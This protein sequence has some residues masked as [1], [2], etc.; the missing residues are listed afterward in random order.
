MNYGLIVLDLLCMLILASLTHTHTCTHT[1]TH[2]HAHSHTHT[3]TPTYTHTFIKGPPQA[4]GW[5]HKSTV[6]TKQ[7][8]TDYNCKVCVLQIA[9]H[10][11][12]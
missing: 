6:L 11:I 7:K 9:Q 3:H 10:Y 1:R 4:V 5:Q 8:C 12:D 2:T